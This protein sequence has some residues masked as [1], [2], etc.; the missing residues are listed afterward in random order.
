MTLTMR[1]TGLSSPA[2]QDEFDVSIYKDGEAVGRIY[3]CG[4]IG[5]P[6]DIRWFW[7]ITLLVDWR[8]AR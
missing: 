4:G 1:P 2:Y 5:M 3:E 7:S 8:S 6:P